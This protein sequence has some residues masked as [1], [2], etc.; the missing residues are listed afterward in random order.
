MGMMQHVAILGAGLMGSS[1]GLAL[2]K[3][4][5]GT[6]ISVYARREQTRREVLERVAADDV[7]ADPADA[8]R[9]ADCV[10]LCVPVLSIANLAAQCLPGLKP[11]AVL[12]DVGSTKTVV[13]REAG[14]VLAGTGHSFVG[15]HPVCGS[16]RQ[17]VEAGDEDLYQGAVTVITPEQE[18][19]TDAV[20][21][22]QALWEAAGSRVC[23]MSAEE[24]DRVLARTSHLPHLVAAAAVLS[25]GDKG[26]LCG[27]G[28]RDTT[29]VASGSPTVWKDILL[30]NRDAVLDALCDYIAHLARLQ[31]DLGEGKGPAVEQWLADAVVQRAALLQT[32]GGRGTE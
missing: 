10:V 30:T 28:F 3:R 22:V 15:S 19:P 24:H 23:R 18:T 5:P 8:V 32:A 20:A 9:E 12:T 1:L 27:S 16:E 21:Q 31:E 11:G 29:R 4:C 14:A 13:Q 2:K 7:F 17:G 25:A 6:R 26:M